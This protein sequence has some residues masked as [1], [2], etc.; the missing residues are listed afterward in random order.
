MRLGDGIFLILAALSLAGCQRPTQ[1]QSKLRAIQVESQRLLATH[2]IDPTKGWADIPR[3][4]WPPVIRSLQ[5]HSVTVF[6]W[7]VDITT[8]PYLDGGWGYEVPLN[9]KHE[10]PMPAECYS[11]LGHGV[12]WHGPC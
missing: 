9:G 6:G 5:P 11:E 8:K 12:F 4:Q 3:S 10:L 7:G 2:R 1:D